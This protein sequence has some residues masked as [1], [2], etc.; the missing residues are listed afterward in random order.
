MR[1]A[2]RRPQA[3][4]R[5]QV[6]VD[7]SRPEV[8]AARQGNPGGSEAS[9]QRAEHHDRRTDALDEV[10]RRLGVQLGGHV[11]D[12]PVI[13]TRHGHAHGFE[14]FAHERYVGDVGHV[15]QHVL[16][17]RQQARRH[18]LEHAVLGA[19]DADFAVERAA[20][21][22]HE[23]VALASWGNVHRH[24]DTTIEGARGNAPRSGD[25]DAG[26]VRVIGPPP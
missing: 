16:P 2:E 21:L 3:L 6:H 9:Q 26:P 24:S 22:R 18:Q 5:L 4:E 25:A 17:L 19:A 11:D 12:Q 13:G 14:Q 7:R 8:V 1:G 20:A 15:G 10:V 23:R